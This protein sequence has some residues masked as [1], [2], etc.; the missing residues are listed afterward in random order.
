MEEKWQAET[1]TESREGDAAGAARG[2]W[3]PN[4]RPLPHSWI[5]GG[6]SLTDMAISLKDLGSVLKESFAARSK[7]YYIGLELGVEASELDAIKKDNPDA[8]K[9]C[10]LETLKCWLKGVAPKPTWTALAE[11]LAS[12]MVDEVGLAEKLREKYCPATDKSPNVG[13]EALR[14]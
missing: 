3:N 10:Y 9:D 1:Q 14:F 5:E 11:A 13:G 4:C 12:D 7:W 6:A 8:V 2:I